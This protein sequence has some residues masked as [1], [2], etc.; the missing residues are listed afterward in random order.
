[1]TKKFPIPTNLVPWQKKYGPGFVLYSEKEGKVLVA[2]RD[3]KKLEEE[4][5]KQ[6]IKRDLDTT[7]LYVPDIKTIS[8]FIVS[9]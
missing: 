9:L 4:A 1:M 5:E 7:V 3:Y 2:A 8:I 6:R